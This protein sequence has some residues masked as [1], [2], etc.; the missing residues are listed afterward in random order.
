MTG[1]V[2]DECTISATMRR[3]RCRQTLTS[4][5]RMYCMSLNRG[6]SEMRKLSFIRE[7]TMGASPK[8][9]DTDKERPCKDLLSFCQPTTGHTGQSHTKCFISDQEAI[10]RPRTCSLA[11]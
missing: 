10:Q 3:W 4:Q 8:P 9:L 7:V 11:L 6:I 1:Y 2:L 5:Y